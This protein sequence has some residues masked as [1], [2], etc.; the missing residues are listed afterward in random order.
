MYKRTTAFGQERQQGRYAAL[1]GFGKRN[2][3]LQFQFGA[4]RRYTSFISHDDIKLLAYRPE[5]TIPICRII[6][7]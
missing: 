2:R 7:R 3:Y 1:S 4:G 6:L 5:D